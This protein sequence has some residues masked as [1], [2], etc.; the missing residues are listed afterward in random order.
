MRFLLDQDVYAVTEQHLRKLGHD[1]LTARAVGMSQADDTDLLAKAAQDQRIFV[2]RDRDF[3]GLVF[4]KGKGGGVIYLRITPSTA[5]AVHAELEVVL[6]RY[7]E[8]HL[9]KAFVVV[10]PGRHRFRQLLS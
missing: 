4:L 10:E 3:G 9:R 8:E 6:S 2:S 5:N 1:A 7:T